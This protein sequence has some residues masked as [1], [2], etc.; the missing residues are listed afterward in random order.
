MIQPTVNVDG[1]KRMFFDRPGMLE[2]MDTA[3]YNALWRAGLNIR[4]AARR[5]LKVRKRKV[6]T[7]RD[8]NGERVED[9]TQYSRPG[10]P[11]Y[12]RSAN[13]ILR[14]LL[15]SSYDTQTRSVVVGPERANTPTGAPETLEYGGNSH[16]W[17]LDRGRRVKRPTRVDARPFMRPAL[18][19]GIANLNQQWRDVLNRTG[20]TP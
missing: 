20:V 6:V 15:T 12:V 13:S 16:G 11:P 18:E 10:Q 14:A 19:K 5:S 2:R 1:M 3:R 8:A 17:E 4:Q 7:I 9:R